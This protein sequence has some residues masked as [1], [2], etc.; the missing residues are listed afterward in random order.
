METI[1]VSGYTREDNKGIHT[2]T[3]NADKKAFEASELIIEENNPTYITLSKDGKHLFTLSDGEEPGVAH[4]ENNDGQFAFKDRVKVFNENGCYVTYDEEANVLYNANY[5]KGELAVI[6]VNEDGTLTVTDVIQHTSPV[7]PHENQDFAHAHFIHPTNDH[8]YILSCDLGTD[9]VHTYTLTDDNKLAEVSVYKAAPGTGPRHLA[10]HHSE[11][12]VY[13]LGELD[14]TVE[15]LNIQEDGS[16]VA[17]NRYDTIPS[18]WTEFN[19]SAAI[20]LSSDNKFLYVSN[21]GHNSIT[22]FE[23]SADG[24]SLTEIQNI[25]T[26]GDFPRDFNFNADESF[27]IVGHQFQPQI[28]LFTRDQASGLLTYVDNTS[29]NEIVCVTPV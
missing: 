13:L 11:P 23:V 10:F 21:R 20:R 25:S 26:E 9:E 1:Y 27:V 4:Y 15:V 5:K 28:S 6:T 17:G 16:L 3:L 22:I 24:Q 14:Y 8:K 29:I 2:L 19:S 18:D 12:I 7:G